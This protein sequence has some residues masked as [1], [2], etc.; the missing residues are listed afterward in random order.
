MRALVFSLLAYVSLS[1]SPAF[2]QQGAEQVR[3]IGIVN[4]PPM[5]LAA[6]RMNGP[7]S[8]T[9]FLSD[10]EREGLLEV[11]NIDPILAMARV[12]VWG[13]NELE[14]QLK[15]NP[16]EGPVN[17]I[18][19]NLPADFFY[20]LYARL[21][22]RTVLRPAALPGPAFTLRARASSKAEAVSILEKAL[23]DNGVATIP[24]GEHFVIVVAQDY[25]AR[26]KPAAPATTTADS[27]SDIL[28]AG[29]INFRSIDMS[30]AALILAELKA[31]KFDQ[32]GTE[33]FLSAPVS[34][35]TQTALT[36]EEAIYAIETVFRLNGVKTLTD[37]NTMRLRSI[38]SN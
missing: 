24:D 3:L 35:R 9:Y 10:G 4:V 12:R 22:A 30:Q 7:R 38:N 34:L 29:T 15:T 5:K 23:A 1:P 13:T 2:C 16:N 36:K 8:Q 19:E 20:T 11:L 33:G 14:L 18:F 32:T 6:I 37:G 26:V 27:K 25:K 21:A 17:L 28:P 31:Q